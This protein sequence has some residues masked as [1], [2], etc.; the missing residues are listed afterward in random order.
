LQIVP[1]KS[2]ETKEERHKHIDVRQFKAEC[3]QLIDKVNQS[4]KP[5]IITKH[6]KPLA[7][8]IPFEEEPLSPY[9]CTKG[10]TIIDGDIVESTGEIWDADK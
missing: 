10:T 2:S 3:L 8:L 5:L 6:G 4:H 1:E 7:K 9:G